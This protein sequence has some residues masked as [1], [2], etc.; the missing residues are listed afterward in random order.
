MDTAPSNTR[1]VDAARRAFQLTKFYRDL[2]KEE[3]ADE[4]AIPYIS[5]T[6]Y[7]RVHGILDCI[8]DQEKI[9]GTKSFFF[10]HLQY[11]SKLLT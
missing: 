3:P 5:S 11:L 9:I 1:L 2:Y 8:V 10:E 6:A 4:A 7:H